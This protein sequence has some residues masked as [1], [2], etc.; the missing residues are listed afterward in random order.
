MANTVESLFFELFRTLHWMSVC[1]REVSCKRSIK[2]QLQPSFSSVGTGQNDVFSAFY[3]KL[4][5]VS[6]ERL[7]AKNDAVGWLFPCGVTFCWTSVS[8]GKGWLY[9]AWGDLIPPLVSISIY[10]YIYVYIY[11]YNIYIYI[12]SWV[13]F[14]NVQNRRAKP[15]N[16]GP[17]RWTWNPPRG[18]P[19]PRAP[20]TPGTRNAARRAGFHGCH[21]WRWEERSREAS[22]VAGRWWY[23]KAGDLSPGGDWNMVD[24]NG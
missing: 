18:C 10:I 13:F 22:E 24:I 20:A 12:I 14:F 1:H 2:K 23:T 9:P 5:L 11:I 8:T 4:V 21:P 19:A 15:G 17:G 7:H 3:T 16:V 6:N